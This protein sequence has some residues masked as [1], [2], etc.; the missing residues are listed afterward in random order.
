MWQNKASSTPSDRQGR[1]YGP[2]CNEKVTSNVMIVRWQ[3][4]DMNRFQ[5]FLRYILYR[6]IESS[7]VKTSSSI[8][9]VQPRSR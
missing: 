7:H 4:R 8:I 3:S 1:T 9:S 6:C 2:V 5:D